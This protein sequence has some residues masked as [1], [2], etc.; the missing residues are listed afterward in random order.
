MCGLQDPECQIFIFTLRL[1]VFEVFHIL[2][3]YIDHVKIQSATIF[4]KLG[5]LPNK[6]NSLYSTMVANV[7]IKFGLRSDENCRRSSDLKFP[8]PYGPLLT[9]ISKCH[10]IFDFWQIAK[11]VIAYSPMTNICIITFGLNRTET[12]GKVAF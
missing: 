9:K 12:V 2:G 3:F 8:P 5:R 7:L 10:K 4:L 6:I 1:T 11:K